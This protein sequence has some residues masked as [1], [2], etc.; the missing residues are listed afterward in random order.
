MA[1]T[2]A[3]TGLYNRRYLNANLDRKILEIARP[4]LADEF[5][6]LLLQRR[7]PR[8]T[9]RGTATYLRTREQ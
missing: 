1:Y 5:R 6:Q 8:R 4:I 2:D 7:R 9:G 3:L